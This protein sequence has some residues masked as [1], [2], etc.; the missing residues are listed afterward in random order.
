MGRRIRN[1]ERNEKARAAKRDIAMGRSELRH[2][3][4]PREA[5]DGPVSF[6]S[7]AVDDDTRR[8]IDEA[9]ARRRKPCPPSA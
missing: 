7:K 3:S 9:V 6:P 1:D 8:M 5:P 4:S 2:P